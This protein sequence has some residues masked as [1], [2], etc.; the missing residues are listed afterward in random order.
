MT[1][2]LI[3]DDDKDTLEF[4]RDFFKPRGC[5]VFTANSGAKA[6]I[7][8]KRENPDVVVSDIKMSGMDGLEVLKK[9]KAF[10]KAIKVI[11]ISVLSDDQTRLKAKKFGADDFFRK[12]LNTLS[13]E[14]SV[15]HHA[16]RN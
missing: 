12:P 9:I 5:S 3:V 4:L 6:I 1:K 15:V 8:A 7:V 10:N 16:V 11:L 13:L 14:S 2:L